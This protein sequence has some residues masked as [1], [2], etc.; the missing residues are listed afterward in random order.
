MKGFN[1]IGQANSMISFLKE[2]IV[3]IKERKKY[4]LY[5][6]FIILGFVGFLIALGTGSSVAPFI[7][8]I[9]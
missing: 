8:A 9:F 5:P 4:W 2:Y 6:I 1:L 3:F 7:Y